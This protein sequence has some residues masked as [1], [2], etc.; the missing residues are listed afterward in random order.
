MTPKALAQVRDELAVRPLGGH[1][2]T[3]RHYNEEFR[4]GFNTAI[5]H[6]QEN[7]HALLEFEVVDFLIDVITVEL[8]SYECRGDDDCDHCVLLSAIEPFSKGQ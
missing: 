7:P 2:G 1:E 8:E 6:L 3:T 4:A 5:K